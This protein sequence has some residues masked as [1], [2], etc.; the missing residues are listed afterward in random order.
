MHIP[1]GLR[2]D[3]LKQAIDNGLWMLT[4]DIETSHNLIR[5]F[6]TQG[7]TYL[8][9]K[10]IK[11]PSKVISIQYKWA[12]ED[13]T[14][15]LV[16]D[17]IGNQGDVR[18]FDDSRMIEQ[19]ITEILPKSHVT[20]TQ[21]GDKYDFITLNERAKALKLSIMDQK[22]SLDILKLSRKSFKAASHKLDYRSGQQ[23]LGGKIQMVDQ[24][25]IDI[26]ENGVPAEVKMIPY[27]CKDTEDTEDLMW[28]EL[29]YYIT[30]PVIVEKTILSYIPSN[31]PEKVTVQKQAKIKEV[32]FKLFC[33][34]CAAKHQSRFQVIDFGNGSY[35]CNN[36]THEWD[37]HDED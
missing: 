24:D 3:Y 17:K 26:E 30:I 18:D 29:P 4:Y 21:N 11:V 5:S 22:P 14:R 23:G 25:W 2:T 1:A 16:W 8:N 19:F 7:K 31:A 13:I 37:T 32:K 35:R 6:P 10:Q 20:V 33:K 34:I 27:G 12:H 28:D 36:C 9:H 15:Y